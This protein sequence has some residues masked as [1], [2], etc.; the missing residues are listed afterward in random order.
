MGTYVI[1]ARLKWGD[2][3]VPVAQVRGTE[4]RATNVAQKIYS[5]GGMNRVVVLDDRFRIKFKVDRR[6]K[7]INVQYT[8][9]RGLVCEACGRVI[10][11]GYIVEA[12]Q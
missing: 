6:C 5:E 10:V 4:E 11:D 12:Y 2:K 8:I 9:D 3:C 7:C 1:L